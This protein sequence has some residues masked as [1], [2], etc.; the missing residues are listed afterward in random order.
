MIN[1]ATI[2][3]GPKDVLKSIK[4]RISENKSINSRFLDKGLKVKLMD[5]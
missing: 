3:V 2:R 5:A 4:L 1:L